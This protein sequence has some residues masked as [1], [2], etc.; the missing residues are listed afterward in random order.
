VDGADARRA[1][2]ALD[3]LGLQDNLQI[4]V[5]PVSGDLTQHLV[6][7]VF[8]YEKFSCGHGSPAAD[9]SGYDDVLVGIRV[10]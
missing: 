6:D 3:D 5:L 9:S 10:D 7:V 4:L 1:G 8:I 2:A